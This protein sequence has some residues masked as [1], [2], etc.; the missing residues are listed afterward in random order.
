M[1]HAALLTTQ[2]NFEFVQSH[3]IVLG[4]CELFWI[5]GINTLLWGTLF[6]AT[7]VITAEPHSPELAFR[8][9]EKYKV[10]FILD[11][12]PFLVGM[13]RSDAINRYDLTSLRNYCTRG[14][15]PPPGMLTEFNVHFPDGRSH[16]FIGM[17]EMAS[18]Y[19]GVCTKYE[20]KGTAGQLMCDV[21]AIVVDDN[22]KR[23]GLNENG[24]LC[25]KPRYPLLGYYNNPDA[26]KEAFD[27]Q[28]FFKTGDIAHFDAVN[29]LY[30]VDRKK[31]I[32]RYCFHQISPSKI[33]AVIMRSP[34][35]LRAC[36]AGIPDNVSIDLPAAAIIR[37]NGST[38][39]EE[40]IYAMVA[41]T[42]YFSLHLKI[43]CSESRT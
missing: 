9:I 2:A 36:V 11:S 37:K 43:T 4:F 14:S 13:L 18:L 1:S 35:I 5:T 42:C 24:E 22:G 6:G 21:E 19:A 3:D 29:D 40:E 32:I 27:A 25:L 10:S 28:G 38:I 7:R 34:E 30:V 8:L 15:K 26:T 17:T 20:D 41:G 12:V 39:T 33:E 16:A 23:C 31:D